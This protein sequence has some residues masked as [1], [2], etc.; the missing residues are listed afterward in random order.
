[1]P[2]I[3]GPFIPGYSFYCRVCGGEK[4]IQVKDVFSDMSFIIKPYEVP[5]YLYCEI[6]YVWCSQ[7]GI[8]YHSDTVR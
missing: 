3:R 8:M 6:E 5:S 2:P 1:M 7:C 4:H